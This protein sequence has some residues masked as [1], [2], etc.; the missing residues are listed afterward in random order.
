MPLKL[1]KGRNLRSNWKDSNFWRN[2]MNM[3]KSCKSAWRR[4]N[5]KKYNLNC[6]SKLM[7]N[8]ICKI[9][10]NRLKK[11]LFDR[12]NINRNLKILMLS[13]NRKM[14]GT[15]RILFSH[16]L[17]SIYQNLRRKKPIM[18]NFYNNN[19]KKNRVKNNLHGKKKRKFLKESKNKWNKE[20]KDT[21]NLEDKRKL[22]RKIL[23]N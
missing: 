3:L 15:K 9:L 10:R 23:K 18:T 2:N 13:M 6:S 14:I 19:W 20:G 21:N 8:R 22:K 17:K 1:T 5:K 11:R 16:K 12:R 7:S 4:E